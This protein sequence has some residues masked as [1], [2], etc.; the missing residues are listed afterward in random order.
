MSR[1]DEFLRTHPDVHRGMGVYS[2]DGE[3]VGAVERLDDESITVEKG[4]RMARDF[5]VRYDDV[6]DIREDHMIL[7]Q[8]HTDLEDWRNEGYSSMG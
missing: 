1:K 2:F 4:W 5:S 3:K 8:N 7:A 6:V